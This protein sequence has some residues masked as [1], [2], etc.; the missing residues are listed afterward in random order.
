MKAH[1]YAHSRV[2]ERH[3]HGLAR[4]ALSAALRPP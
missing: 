3:H 2:A 4:A 1:N